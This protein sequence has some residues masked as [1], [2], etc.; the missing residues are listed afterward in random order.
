MRFGRG[1]DLDD[2]FFVIRV[3]P[4]QAVFEGIGYGLPS[5]GASGNDPQ[6]GGCG[7]GRQCH[8]RRSGCCG[9]LSRCGQG[10]GQ[11][12]RPCALGLEYQAIGQAAQ[13]HMVEETGFKLEDGVMK[14]RFADDQRFPFLLVRLFPG[15][16]KSGCAG[17]LIPD[18][19][20]A[21]TVAEASGTGQDG[22][23]GFGRAGR[24]GGRVC[25]QGQ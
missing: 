11:Y 20:G 7:Q 5:D 3:Y 6:I 19:L 15:D 17:H 9:C 12:A 21:G 23:G 4:A 24:R 8:I 1:A 10:K 18:K 16:F 13:P 22:Q 14:L 25:G 2:G